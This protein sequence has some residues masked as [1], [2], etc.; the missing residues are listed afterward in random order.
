MSQTSN[1]ENLSPEE[2]EKSVNPV[3]E[4]YRRILLAAIGAVALTQD[5]LEEFVQKLVERG[6]IA[7]QDG[8]KLIKEMSEKRRKSFASFESETHKRI[9]EVMKKLNIPTREDIEELNIKITELTR[10]IDE[11]K[12]E[13]KAKES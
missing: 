1:A 3:V 7:E 9:Y 12:K 2:K 5:A 13:K 11:L 8:K 6:E 10:K 4:A